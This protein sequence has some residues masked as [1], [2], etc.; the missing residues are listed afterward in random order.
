M[1]TIYKV[2]VVS[3]WLSYSKEELEKILTEV[4]NKVERE[5]GNTI[6]FRVE[7]KK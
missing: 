2:E 4:V 5:K 7:E 1:A 3:H 6:Q